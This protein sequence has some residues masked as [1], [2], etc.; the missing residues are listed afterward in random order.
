MEH[1][2]SWPRAVY[3][4][5]NTVP[6]V[7]DVSNVCACVCQALDYCHSMGIMHRDV[8]PHNV[9]IDHQQKKVLGHQGFEARLFQGNLKLCLCPHSLGSCTD[10]F[11]LSLPDPLHLCL[12]LEMD[13][14]PLGSTA[15]GVHGLDVAL[16]HQPTTLGFFAE[17]S[18]S[19]QLISTQEGWQ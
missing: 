3:C 10:P 5:V 17:R 13:K 2:C 14:V 8:K 15:V 7:T 4:A 19:G 12:C 9:M 1:S 16:L 11:N 6:V 18:S